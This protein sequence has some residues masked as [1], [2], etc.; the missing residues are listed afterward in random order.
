MEGSKKY[1]CVLPCCM[2]CRVLLRFSFCSLY[3]HPQ[4]LCLSLFL[5]KL[6]SEVSEGL[7]LLIPDIVNEKQVL[8]TGRLIVSRA[9]LHP[10]F[11]PS[12]ALSECASSIWIFTQVDTWLEIFP[13]PFKFLHYSEQTMSIT[14]T[15]LLIRCA[16]DKSRIFFFFQIAPWTEERN[17]AFPCVHE[18]LLAIS[19]QLQATTSGEYSI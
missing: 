15:L 1:A 4:A 16:G 6:S 14:I 7:A 9:L 11:F 19:T 10:A 18:F 5:L 2:L 13:I 17:V 12:F 3:V 8:Y